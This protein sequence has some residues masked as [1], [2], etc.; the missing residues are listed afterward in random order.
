MSDARTRRAVCGSIGGT[1]NA[2]T[3]SSTHTVP[4]DVDDAT[5]A[6]QVLVGVDGSAA[7]IEALRWSA[8]MIGRSG[9][10]MTAVYAFSPTYAEMD[11]EQYQAERTEAEHA[12]TGWCAAAGV[13]VE[14]LVVGGGPGALLTMA[15][16]HQVLLVVGTSGASGFARLHLGRVANHLAHHTSTPL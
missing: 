1:V 9:Q 11:P 4:R 6:D 3:S 15:E 12:L 2:G 16:A 8:S 13:S 10:A 5:R 7:S 14:T